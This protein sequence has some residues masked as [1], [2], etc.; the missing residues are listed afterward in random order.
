VQV[1]TYK[2]ICQHTGAEGKNVY[3]NLEKRALLF[4][5]YWIV[6]RCVCLLM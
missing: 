6:K 2:D 1:T 3:F 4:Q 5:D